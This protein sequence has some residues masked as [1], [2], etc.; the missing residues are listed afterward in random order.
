M[1][2]GPVFVA[3]HDDREIASALACEEAGRGLRALAVPAH[4][5]EQL[6]AHAGPSTAGNPFADVPELHA[7]ASW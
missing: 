6:P 1:G 5:H 3:A 2:G 4:H 7:A